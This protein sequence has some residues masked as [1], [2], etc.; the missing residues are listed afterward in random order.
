MILRYAHTPAVIRA[1]L[2]LILVGSACGSA[3][4]YTTHIHTMQFV[5]AVLL[6]SRFLVL[7]G[8][9]LYLHTYACLPHTPFIPGFGSGSAYLL[10]LVRG[11]RL[12]PAARLRSAWLLRSP[13]HRFPWLV[14]FCP[15][16]FTGS[17]TLYTFH[18]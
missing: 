14:Y 16:Y 2:C 4:R 1:A 13:T 8:L 5:P 18:A 15:A 6:S 11:Y 17:L 7:A 3:V 9:L 12:V 10:V